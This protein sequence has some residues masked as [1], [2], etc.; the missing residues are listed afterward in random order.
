MGV[1]KYFDKIYCVNLDRRE[2][3]W[4]E[5]KV[6][7]EKWGLLEHVERY[8]A[9]DGNEINEDTLK[10]TKLN[11]GG[12]GLLLTNIKIIEECIENDYNN[13]LIL[14]DDIAFN[15]NIKIIDEYF[16]KLPEE[17]DM[18]YLGGN[19]NT[20]MGETINIINDK[21]I[22]LHNTF[23]THCV[24]FNKSIYEVILSVLNRKSKPIDV[25]YTQIQRSHDCYG[26]YPG[27][28]LQRA[29]F[30]DI[31]NKDTDNNWLFK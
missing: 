25:A 3:R 21:I 6:E 8:S 19:H 23:A 30:S 11:K 9:I 28:G 2:D 18:L 20:H 27:M 5:T 14:E 31:E 16:K 29:S 15:D 7:L 22:K 12:L 4:E 24:A 10:T 26:F 13:V 17:W 1:D